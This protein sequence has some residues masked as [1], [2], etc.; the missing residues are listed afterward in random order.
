MCGC[1]VDHEIKGQGI[2]AYV[3]LAEGTKATP[4]LKKK[5][6]EVVKSQIGSFAVPDT[7]HWA[8]GQSCM[9]HDDSSCHASQAGM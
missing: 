6:N 3:V 7:I 8:P 1:R 5:L 4:E 2:Y 9:T